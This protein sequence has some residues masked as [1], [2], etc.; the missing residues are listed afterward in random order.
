MDKLIDQ[1]VKSFEPSSKKALQR[2][3]EF[4]IHIYQIYGLRMSFCRSE[5]IKNKYI[6]ERDG[7]LEY[8]VKNK[9]AI[10]K[11]LSK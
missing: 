2:Y 4:L 10:L 6:K 11:Q 9:Q 1:V 8:A 3:D 7:I 5:K